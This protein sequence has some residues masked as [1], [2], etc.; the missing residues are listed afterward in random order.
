MP[1]SDDAPMMNFEFVSNLITSPVS[2]NVIQSEVPSQY[3][4]QPVAK[5]FDPQ[6]LILR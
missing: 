1:L 6:T 3:L 2:P 5:L 4:R